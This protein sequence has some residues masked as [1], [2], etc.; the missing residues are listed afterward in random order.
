M[1]ILLL[2]MLSAH[3]H[4]SIDHETVILIGQMFLPIVVIG[5]V[6]YKI[7]KLY[8]IIIEEKKGGKKL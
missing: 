5:F 2:M 3:V 7:L 4:S 6:I 8:G 1:R